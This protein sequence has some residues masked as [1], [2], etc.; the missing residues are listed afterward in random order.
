MTDASVQG[1]A[2]WNWGGTW[3]SQEGVYRF[4]SRWGTKDMPYRYFTSVHNPE[5]LKVSPAE[6][7]AWYPSFFTV[8]FSVLTA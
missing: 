5:I 2:W 6:L 7:L 1:Y 3:L 8:P 4:K